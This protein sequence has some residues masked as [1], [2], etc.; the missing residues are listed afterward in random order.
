MK[1]KEQLIAEHKAP[2]LIVG[3]V[4][5]VDIPYIK[6]D[7]RK[8]GKKGNYEMVEIECHFRHTGV[9]E[10]L[11]EDGEECRATF[12]SHS[13]PFEIG[14]TF[15]TKY[16]TRNAYRIGY[17]PFIE[18]NWWGRIQFT[19]YQLQSLINFL[20]FSRASR[21]YK[22]DQVCAVEVPEVNWNP[23][24]IGENGEEISYQ[25][26]FVW[27]L[28]DKQLLIESIY[29]NL[30]IGKILV[31]RRSYNWVKKRVEEGKEAAFTDIVDGKQRCST[32][33]D[34]LQNKFPDMHGHYWDD[35][36]GYAQNR[37]YDYNGFAFGM[38]GEEATD[39]D[40]LN[41]FLNVNFTGVQLSQEHLDYVKSI[42][43]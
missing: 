31:R 41:S 11:S 1:T 16:A 35:L 26:D 38:L 8:K 3:D 21:S 40:V 42:K 28:Q 4:I 30:E 33:L 2:P 34:F 22:F 14:K 43:I 15:L 24:V 12:E 6:K 29:N 39:K 10:W 17:N 20:G 5:D 32:I 18:I 23:F 36:S 9:I 27:T 37:F 19:A 25:R 13:L 7:Y